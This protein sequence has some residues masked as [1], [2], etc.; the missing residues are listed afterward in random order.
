[1]EL[2]HNT[3]LVHLQVQSTK[4]LVEE[5]YESII[6]AEKN[7]IEAEES[8]DETKSSFEVGINSTTDLLIAQTNW[9]TARAQ[10]IEA[11]AKYRVLET[12]WQKVTG[13]L[14]PMQ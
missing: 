5:A 7:I 10:R 13:Q 3:D 14:Q 2:S 4:V 1:M 8:L 12:T 9:L 11:I 6:I